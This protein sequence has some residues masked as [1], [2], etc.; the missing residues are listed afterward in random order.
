LEVDDGLSTNT[1][2]FQIEIQENNAPVAVINS[3]EYNE[4]L[5]ITS[6]IYFDGSGCSDPENQELYYNWTSN[7]DGLLGT[8]ESFYLNLSA[9]LHIITLDVNDG[10]GCSSETKM[11]ITVN[12]PTI[13]N[14]GA[15]FNIEL[16]NF[17]LFDGS[18]SSDPDDD[19][20]IFKWDFGD[21]TGDIG[22]I[23][24]HKYNSDGIYYVTLTVDDGKG[25][26]STDNLIV[27]VIYVFTGPGIQGYVYNNETYEPLDGIK[28]EAYSWD[29]DDGYFTNYTKTN[30]SGYYEIRTPNG[31]IWLEINSNDYYKFKTSVP[32]FDNQ[33]MKKDIFLDPE[34]PVTA[35]IFG[36]VYDNKT[37]EL[38]HNAHISIFDS[39]F[40]FNNWTD[41]DG[42][43]SYQ[44]GAPAGEFTI[45]CDTWSGNIEYETYIMQISLYD[46]QELRHDIYLKR[47]RPNESNLTFEFFPSNWNRITVIDKNI[48][49]YDTWEIRADIDQNYDGNVTEAEVTAYELLQES[50][51]NTFFSEFDT[52]GFLE[53]D[54]ISYEYVQNSIDIEIEGAVGPT[55]SNDP[56]TTT[57]FMEIKSKQPINDS[58]SHNILILVN[59]DWSSR[60]FVYYVKLP[61]L[62]KLSNNTEQE[63][64]SVTED[65]EYLIKID[66]SYPPN[67]WLDNFE[68]ILWIVKK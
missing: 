36:F 55:M 24:K 32:V 2:E 57:N 13:A 61:T 45:Y 35:K 1:E 68:I 22:E 27:T 38:L 9:G 50:D 18:N 4:I 63:N 56:I 31:Y 5:L 47:Q 41:T 21:G 46:Y 66:P 29:N 48:E 33:I 49:Y 7:L 53:V 51:F 39:N 34:P 10:F 43:G 40:K 65:G 14:A 54:N 59:Y 3:P 8:E 12:S 30:E 20:L 15:D 60:D 6:E 17:A 44:V 58:N 23:V 16:G 42:N 52:K 37:K 11:V 67:Y 25:G 26:I 62:F 19:E 28:I 64:I